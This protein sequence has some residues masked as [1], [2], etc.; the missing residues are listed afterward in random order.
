MPAQR[1][2]QSHKTLHTGVTTSLQAIDRLRYLNNAP[3]LSHTIMGAVNLKHNGN[4]INMK[5]RMN[6]SRTGLD[7]EEKLLIF[8]KHEKRGEEYVIT[9]YESKPN[10][11]DRE[12]NLLLQ[13][14]N[15]TLQSPIYLNSSNML[16]TTINGV[17]FINRENSKWC[18]RFKQTNRCNATFYFT[19]YEGRT[20]IHFI[21]HSNTETHSHKE[22]V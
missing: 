18:C 10:L 19:F 17:E 20:R 1:W 6:F 7:V 16:A 14:F 22:G 12:V 13:C 4:Y 2:V 15:Q 5:S 3:L 21:P 9:F 8:W 11:T